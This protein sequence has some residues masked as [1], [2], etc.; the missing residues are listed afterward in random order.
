MADYAPGDRVEVD[1]S[2]GILP[3]ADPEPDWRSGSVVARL[4]N[5]M[6]RIRLDDPI[7][8]QAAEKEARP[9]HI[10]PAR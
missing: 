10:R 1:I 8:G 4:D 7:A 6:V 3:S 9:E 5:G 2:A